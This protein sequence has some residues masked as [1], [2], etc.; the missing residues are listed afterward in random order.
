MK[1][2]KADIHARV[3][4]IPRVV[5]EEESQMTPYAGVVLLQA[6]FKA[7]NF[8]PRLRRCFSH[9][10]RLGIFGP[11][12]LV[13]LLVLHI[14]LG[15]RRLRGLDYYRNDPM[16]ARV[17]GLRRLPDVATV[18]RMLSEADAKSVEKLRGLSRELVLDRLTAEG[19]ARVTL[20]F[21]G[22]VQSTKGHR[23]GT[24]VGFNRQKKG[25]RSYYPLFC[26]V[27]QTSQFLDI[28]HRPGNVH[29]SNGASEFMKACID[30]VQQRLPNTAVEIRIDSAF[31][32]LELL[33]VL[34]S[35]DVAFTCSVPFLRLQGLKEEVESRGEWQRID[36]TWSFFETSWRPKTWEGG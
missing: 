33:E 20:D 25:A 10:N 3:H 30:E 28:H 7:L 27:A 16:V 23:E 24:A 5:F 21:D 22:S 35:R 26:T 11:A 15:Y 36:G 29:D 12:K 6:L 17:L 1:S 32:A 18:S 14:S 31:F 34:D 8:L 9:V 2:S 4:S 13:L 19:F